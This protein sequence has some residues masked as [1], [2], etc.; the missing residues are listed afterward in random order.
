MV[1][2]ENMF[3]GHTDEFGTSF[4]V[5]ITTVTQYNY[6]RNTIAIV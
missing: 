3:Y 4:I 2:T 5:Y 1:Q 6:N